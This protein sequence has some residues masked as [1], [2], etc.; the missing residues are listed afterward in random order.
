MK[1]LILLMLILLLLFSS[2]RENYKTFKTPLELVIGKIKNKHIVSDEQI[3]IKNNKIIIGNKIITYDDIN[4]LKSLP[5]HY[6]TKMCFP[7][8]TG[9]CIDTTDFQNLKKYWNDGTII[10]YTGELDSIPPNW[11]ICDGSNGTP[12]L[13]DRFIIG[14]GTNY[15]KGS[16]GGKETH[17]LTIDELPNHSHSMVFSSS[18]NKMDN[19]KPI[20]VGDIRYGWYGGHAGMDDFM[21]RR[22]IASKCYKKGFIEGTDYIPGNSLMECVGNLTATKKDLY[23]NVKYRNKL[24]K[25]PMKQYKNRPTTSPVKPEATLSIPSISS[26]II[27]MEIYEP[28]PLYEILYKEK[29]N[30]KSVG[31]RFWPGDKVCHNSCLYYSSIDNW[32]PSDIDNLNDNKMLI[33]SIL[34]NDGKENILKKKEE[35]IL[36]KKEKEL[37]PELVK[38]NVKPGNGYY[39]GPTGNACEQCH[40]K[41][42]TNDSAKGKPHDN[43]P[44]YY[45]VIFIMRTVHIKHTTTSPPISISIKPEIPYKKDK[46]AEIIENIRKTGNTPVY[47]NCD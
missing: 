44:S 1:L 45:R 2:F 31:H 37:Y 19:S 9:E 39:V 5:V 12:D 36:Q 18:T 15:K 8:D 11:S 20:K 6:D 46:C 28:I 4:A 30:I 23:G 27:D 16:T 24:S 13:R 22:T 42:D 10:A 41:T 35:N 32:S 29:N 38:Q 33:K 47:L 7:D 40:N 3:I 21:L 43:M 34:I 26:G 17:S 14:A 25:I